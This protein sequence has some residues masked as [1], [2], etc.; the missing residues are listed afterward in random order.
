MN[1]KEGKT[2]DKFIVEKDGKEIEVVFR[3]PKM[4]DARQIM[5]SYNKIINET[6]FLSSVKPV[7]LDKEKK[8][9]KE[10]LKDTKKNDATMMIA[11]VD[12]NIIGNASVIRDKKEAMKHTG[13]FG[14]VLIH[15]FTGI[16]IGS[17]L[18]ETILNL[19]KNNMKT[20]I[21]KSKYFSGNEQSLKL[22][23][24][25]GFKVIGKIPDGFKKKIKIDTG[26]KYC[27]IKI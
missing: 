27:C 26:M 7:S 25:F 22:H 14:I 23:K 13:I 12:S 11:E 6:P 4:S 18:T 2:I 8:W 15:K 20:E 21:I 17:R 10:I 16:G 3:Y 1:F 19:A 5:E 9:L 24:K